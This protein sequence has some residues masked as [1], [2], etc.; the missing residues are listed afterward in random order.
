MVFSLLD[1]GGPFTWNVQDIATID[2]RKDAVI[3][4]S[5]SQGDSPAAPF[6]FRNA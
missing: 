5:D 6:L 1:T 3:V 2:M 4:T